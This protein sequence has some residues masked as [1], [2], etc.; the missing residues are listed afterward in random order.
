MK[1]EK[2]FWPAGGFE[3]V[4]LAFLLLVGPGMRADFRTAPPIA[5][6]AVLQTSNVIAYASG[7]LIAGLDR[8]QDFSIEGWVF[9]P[10]RASL[11]TLQNFLF[12]QEPVAVVELH[13][14][15]SGDRAEVF[16]GVATGTRKQFQGSTHALAW[17]AFE[18]GCHH[19]ACV[20]SG[21]AG[22]DQTYLDGVRSTPDF[23]GSSTYGQRPAVLDQVLIAGGY[24]YVKLASG[25]YWDEIHVARGRRYNANFGPPRTPIVPTADTLA[26]WR[27]D[28]AAGSGV[29]ADSSGHGY[30]LQSA[31]DAKTVA[32][33]LSLGPTLVIEQKAAGQLALRLMGETGKS[34]RIE[35]APDLVGWRLLQEVQLLTGT[36]TVT[37]P[38]TGSSTAQFFR[39]RQL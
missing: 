13:K 4:W 5:G 11:N 35:T 39:A 25:L 17:A 14:S 23:A 32:L 22:T 27:F 3:L 19:L 30:H 7:P 31:F 37:V 10:P 36:Q 34:Y 16:F 24:Q 21:S 28:E 33:P 29:F 2:R 15:P 1:K 8:T 6:G 26:L 20:H 38:P 18:N 12:F 9:I